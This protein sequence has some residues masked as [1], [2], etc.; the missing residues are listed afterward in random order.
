MSLTGPF[1]RINTGRGHR[2][3]DANGVKVPGVTTILNNGVPKP[4][5]VNWAA[6]EAA[7]FAVDNWDDLASKGIAERMKL[8]QG[9]HNV[10]KN[11]AAARGTLVH[12]YAERL[13]NGE[14]VDVPDEVRGHVESCLRF[15]DEFE[16]V[17]VVS[18]ST[19]YSVTHGYAGTFDVIF[20][21]AEHGRLLCDWKT[22]SSGIYGEVALQ[23]AA[24]RFAEF[25]D[26]GD[27]PVPMP[28]VDGC[29]VIHLQA[30]SYTVRMVE[31][32]QSAFDAFLAAK[33]VAEFRADAD[34]F[35]GE[36]ITL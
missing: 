11:A 36:A 35:V 20:D 15:L 34:D 1:R 8:I 24:Y 31:A 28:D 25:Y 22:N 3:V 13:A 23:L 10:R 7:S 16:P 14:Q 29:A 19:V 27:Q 17:T 4:A 26:D 6:R 12:T 5:L 18:E 32:T 33:R 21:T 9:A 30:D 2:Y